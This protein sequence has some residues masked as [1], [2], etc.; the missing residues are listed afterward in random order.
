MGI[1]TAL[2]MIH[3]IDMEPEPPPHICATCKH[4]NDEAVFFDGQG[5][6]E[7]VRINEYGPNNPPA[8][9][10]AEGCDVDAWLITG[11]GHYCDLWKAA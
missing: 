11:A 4:W 6:C 3:G 8:W 7:A 10:S 9:I 2:E 1:A 5:V